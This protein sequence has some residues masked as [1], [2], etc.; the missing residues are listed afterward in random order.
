MLP[1]YIS[2]IN[3][4][5]FIAQL[6]SEVASPISS[7]L[8]AGT[9]DIANVRLIPTFWNNVTTPSLLPTVQMNF[10][11]DSFEQLAAVLKLRV[12]SQH[13]TRFIWESEVLEHYDFHDDWERNLPLFQARVTVDIRCPVQVVHGWS[14]T[15][16][17]PRETIHRHY[18]RYQRQSTL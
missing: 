2:N 3:S 1:K 13:V 6:P 10:H 12:I 11:P 16:Q 7:H 4:P 17:L 18:A 14:S 8:R 15:H 5:Y 9:S